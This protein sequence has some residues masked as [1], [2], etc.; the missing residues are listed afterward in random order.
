[1]TVSLEHIAPG[2]WG[3]VERVRQLLQSL[4]IDA[5]ID[6]TTK[7]PRSVGIRF[8]TATITWPGGTPFA[9]VAVTHG[10][11]R[12]PTA[13]FAG[14]A[15]GGTMNTNIPVWSATSPGAT[16]FT[17]AAETSDASAPAVGLTRTFY[18][19]AVG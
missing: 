3:A 16:T 8:G 5:G 13:V 6:A 18:W 2:D 1:M 15:G 17:A 14:D 11:G 10:L 4:V 7:L 12:T 19:L 9:T